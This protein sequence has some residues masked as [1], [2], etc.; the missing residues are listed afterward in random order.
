MSSNKE[1]PAMQ[2]IAGL[3]DENSFVEIGSLVTARSTDF[4]LSAAKT[5]SDGVITG[6]GLID[7]NLVFVYSQ[8]A[9]VL[10]GSIGEMHAKKIAGIYDM[11]MKMGAP[12]IGLID[13]AGVRVQESIDA[14]DGF[15]RIFAKAAQA[16]GIIPQICA[17]FGSCGG[18]LSI[19]PA[20][21]DFVFVEQ[22]K[23]RMFVNSPDAIKGNRVEKCD[24]A[25]ADF[26]A[27]EN[28]CIDMVGSSDDILAS[29]RY[30]V[31]LLPL[32][33]EGSAYTDDCM[34]DL[35]R[36]CEGVASLKDDPRSLLAEVSDDNVFF[37]TKTAYAPCTVTGFIKLNGLTVGVV[38]NSA[39][40]A[41]GMPLEDG[42]VICAH[43]AGKAA[44]FIQFCDA[45][46]IPVLSVTNIEGYKASM[47]AEKEL[48]R[49]LAKM[50]AAFAQA[51]VGKVNLITGSAYGSASVS[52]NSK[53]IG[54]DLVYAWPNAKVG[55][56]EA[57]LAA[58]LLYPKADAKEIAE[59]TAEYEKLQGSVEAAAAR[60]QVDQII[61]PEDT[62]KYL[63]AAFEL[64]YTKKVNEPEKKHTAK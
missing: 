63:I 18:G 22:D 16:S 13:C 14:L 27:K 5:P 50:T 31:T 44:D 30:L 41:D 60:G 32:N 26:A 38:A 46:S 21:N 6:H 33:Y 10:G 36:L 8:D 12:V 51:T 48:A 24:T 15:G 34:D 62:R 2:R 29:I 42:R 25:A 52:M 1:N 58:K 57:S 45:F 9:S 47:S 11:A 61:D 19:L 17:I 54:A 23:G 39:V 56:M 59:K 35:N 4:N 28:G 37:E 7:G 40:D 43:G 55:A 3:L 64:L 20:L 53:S 49:A